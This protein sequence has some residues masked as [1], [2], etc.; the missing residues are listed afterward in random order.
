MNNI[1]NGINNVVKGNLSIVSVLDDPELTLF[2]ISNDGCHANAVTKEN[3]HADIPNR[4]SMRAKVIKSAG[5]LLLENEL[6]I[7]QNTIDLFC[8]RG[9]Y[10]YFSLLLKGNAYLCSD[11][12]MRRRSQ[13]KRLDLL[14]QKRLYFRSDTFSQQTIQM[15][16]NEKIRYTVLLIHKNYAKLLL[17][18]G[19]SDLLNCHL[20]NNIES[21]ISTSIPLEWNIHEAI[22]SLFNFPSEEKLFPHFAKLKLTEI[23]LLL[24]VYY[25]AKI[26]TP[27]S[28]QPELERFQ[29]I[30]VWITVNYNREFT[31]KSLARNFGLNELILKTGFKAAFGQTI[32]QFVIERRMNAAKS[33]ILQN[34]A[35][36]NEISNKV[37]YRSVSH[38]IQ[39]FK[40]H[41]G[42][43]PAQHQ[44]SNEKQ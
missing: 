23:L 11:N 24:N 36:I 7:H 42:A 8:C 26:E 18:N 34:R 17:Q 32:R 28:S 25:Q 20:Y 22:Q 13:S 38:F 31:L 19:C 39:T 44:T 21:S 30:K 33:M 43:T 35:T 12:R 27:L 2:D 14:D 15:K 4:L 9:D 41:F 1:G 3:I 16:T 10:F 29:E 6:N 37:G 5:F 40:K